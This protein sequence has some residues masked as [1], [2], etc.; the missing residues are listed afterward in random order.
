LSFDLV[1]CACGWNEEEYNLYYQLFKRKQ[2]DPK[3]YKNCPFC[4]VIVHRPADVKNATKRSRCGNKKCVC[5]QDWCWE[6]REPW[7]AETCGKN[8][9]TNPVMEKNL[10]LKNCPTKKFGWGDNVDTVVP[11][12]RACIN[13]EC[14]QIY[15]HSG[16]CN[17]MTC[18]LCKTQFCFICLQKWPCPKKYSKHNDADIAERQVLKQNK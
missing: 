5:V 17:H 8:N 4:Y 13:P 1:A 10:N 12:F 18:P 15:Q 6:C 11:T 9:C 2:L 3:L 16:A 14:Q 7:K